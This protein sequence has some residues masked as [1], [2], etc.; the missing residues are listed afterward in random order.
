MK[1]NLML[2]KYFTLTTVLIL[3]TLLACSETSTGIKDEEK[4]TVSISNPL[5]NSE[6]AEGTIITIKVETA[7]N[8][9]I[10]KVEFYIDGILVSTDNTLEYDYEWN[11]DS[12]IGNHSI[13]AKAY[14]TNDNVGNSGTIYVKITNEIPVALFTVSPVSGDAATVFHVDASTSSDNEDAATALEVRWDWEADG[15]WDTEYST[16]KTAD[17]QYSVDGTMRIRLEV[18]DTDNQTDTTSLQIIVNS[19]DPGTV[20]DFD[21]NVYNTVKIGNQWWL[22]ENLRVTH[23]NDGTEIPLIFTYSDWALTKSGAYCYYDNDAANIA[24]YGLLYNFYAVDNSRGLAPEG[25]HVPSSEE[26]KELEMHMGMT[27]EQA[28]LTLWRGT[29]EGGKLKEVG[30]THWTSPNTGATNETGFTAIP[31]GYRNVSNYAMYN[32]Y[33]SIG[34]LGSFWTSTGLTAS[35]NINALVRSLTN[36]ETRISQVGY[37]RAN[38]LSVRCVKD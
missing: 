6:W 23:Y 12:Q 28:D 30:T 7:D 26:W 9:G 24:E 17:H 18:K 27:Q 10:A 34:L 4:P 5:N 33:R 32:D 22:V 21:G 38:G 36:A 3:L 31:G 19:V 11:T 35:N 14:D 25:W 29:D 1:G 2:R 13:Q 15:T 8:E 16:V 37:P 20:T